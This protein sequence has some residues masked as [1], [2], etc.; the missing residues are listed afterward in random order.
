MLLMLVRLR[1]RRTGLLGTMTPHHLH[2]PAAALTVVLMFPR[3]LMALLHPDH[4]VMLLVRRRRLLCGGRR[5]AVLMCRG[6]RLGKSRA[7]NSKRK[8]AGDENWAQSVHLAL[9]R[10]CRLYPA[11]HSAAAQ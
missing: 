11:P 3:L 10:M 6:D 2:H 1:G 8:Y 7:G 4:A 9:P 5:L